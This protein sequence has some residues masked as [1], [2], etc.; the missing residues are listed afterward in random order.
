[1]KLLQAAAILTLIASPVLAAQNTTTPGNAGQSS[2]AGVSGQAGGKNGPATD[3][4]GQVA[5]SDQSN[6]T[7]R[8]Q[9]SSKIPGKA[10]SK[11][12]PAVMPPTSGSGEKH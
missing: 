8:L 1:M 10:G 12:G 9:D 2:G 5:N 4:Q 7:T 3:T 11:S 6:S